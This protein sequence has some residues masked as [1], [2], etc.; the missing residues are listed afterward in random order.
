MKLVIYHGGKLIKW[1]GNKEKSWYWGGASV[2]VDNHFDL[3]HLSFINIKSYAKD[4]GYIDKVWTNNKTLGY[5][6]ELEDDSKVEQIVNN[7]NHRE[8]LNI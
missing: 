1:N 6:I 3:D 8:T 2:V 7:L 5:L 4:L